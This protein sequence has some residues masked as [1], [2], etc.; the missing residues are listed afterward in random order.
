MCCGVAATGE[1]RCE[2]HARKHRTVSQQ[3]Y[4]SQRGTAVERGYDSDH[5]R[6][7]VLCFQRDDWRC[8]TCGWE[9]DVMCDCRLAGIDAPPA[10][11]VLE[12]LRLAKNVSQR[13]LHADH[14]V[15]ITGR[16]DPRRLDLGNLQTLCDWCHRRKT[17]K[18]NA[19]GMAT[20]APTGSRSSYLGLGR[21][22]QRWPSLGQSAHKNFRF[23][24]EHIKM[25]AKQRFLMPKQARE[26]R[27]LSAI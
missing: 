18:E 8:C 10:E 23:L 11:V 22:D 21:G 27:H 4:D 14:V 19:L 15:P 7:Q 24:R 3:L 6:L 25:P 5:Q 9:P 16:D 2:E 13:H 17:M 1:S 20:P 12:E 26:L